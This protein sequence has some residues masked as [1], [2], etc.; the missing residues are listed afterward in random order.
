MIHKLYAEPS[1]R[2]KTKTKLFQLLIAQC[3][4]IHDCAAGQLHSLRDGVTTAGVVIK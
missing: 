1:R 3:N 2:K 4:V